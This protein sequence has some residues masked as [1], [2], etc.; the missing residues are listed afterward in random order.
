M[1]E[2]TK[3]IATSDMI[4]SK[5]INQL[6][7]QQAAFFICWFFWNPAAL[8]LSSL[9]RRTL[10]QHIAAQQDLTSHPPLQWRGGDASSL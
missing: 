1:E 8:L 2:V 9:L 3:D 4:F 5:F 6:F 10:V 7:L